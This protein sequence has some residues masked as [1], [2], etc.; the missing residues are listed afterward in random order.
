MTFFKASL[1]K[2]VP[3]ISAALIP[4]GTWKSLVSSGS[5]ACTDCRVRA[6]A[7]KTSRANDEGSKRPILS[8]GDKL[9]KRICALTSED[10]EEELFLNLKNF[11]KTKSLVETQTKI[12]EIPQYPKLQEA[13]SGNF[14]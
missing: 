6:T 11:D 7:T 2:N 12:S 10:F 4:A 8:D 14:L 5:E 1:V 3:S 13:P 9:L